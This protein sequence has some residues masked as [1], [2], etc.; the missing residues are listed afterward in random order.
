MNKLIARAALRWFRSNLGKKSFFAWYQELQNIANEG[1]VYGNDELILEAESNLIREIA[2]NQNHQLVVFDVGANIGNYSKKWLQINPQL[3]AFEPN[4]EAFKQLKA[5]L[6]EKATVNHLAFS[7]KTGV[8]DLYTV[9][10]AHQ[11]SSLIKRKHHRHKWEKAEQVNCHT[12]DEYCASNKI[13]KIDFL[14][15]DVE[16]FEMEVLKGAK[17]M[18]AKTTRIQFEFGGAHIE[19]ALYFRDFY[20]LLSPNFKLYHIL[21]DGF[22]EI[23]SYDEKLENFKGTNYLAINRKLE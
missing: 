10:G 11:L 5:N 19:Q 13:K 21:I 12:I 9:K 8:Q 23:S 16:G 7:N 1:M 20:N 17:Q 14:K 4:S 6:K 2:K 22:K 18:L 15:I 3:H